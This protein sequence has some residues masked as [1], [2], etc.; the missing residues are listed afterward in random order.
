[1]F[2]SI[3]PTIDGRRRPDLH[4]CPTVSDDLPDEQ[5]GEIM[6][7]FLRNLGDHGIQVGPNMV[8]LNIR[9]S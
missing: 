7:D 8:E 2:I 9:F 1:M 3:M 4:R 6:G 5:V